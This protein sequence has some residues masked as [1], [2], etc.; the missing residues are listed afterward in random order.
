MQAVRGDVGSKLGIDSWGGMVNFDPSAIF[1]ITQ[2]PKNR[3]FPACPWL[4]EVDTVY[5]FTLTKRHGEVKGTEFFEDALRYAQ[6]QWM[7]GK[8]AQ[9]ILQLNK[10]WMAVL[11]DGYRFGGTHSP[12]RALAWILRQ[13]AA[14]SAGYLG[15][16]VRHFQHLASRISGPS[17][18]LRS[19]RAWVCFHLAEKIL[20]DGS[21]PRDGDQIAREGLWIPRMER[22]IA[23]VAAKGWAGEWKEIRDLLE[24]S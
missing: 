10:A 19:W 9:A 23:E 17:A 24:G 6:S 2:P 16:P 7:A 1:V 15:N 11:P 8:P 18:E 22:A 5:D 13:A 20:V 14:G 12:Y 4:P 3:H 21:F